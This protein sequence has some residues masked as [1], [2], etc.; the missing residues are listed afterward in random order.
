MNERT[1][2]ALGLLLGVGSGKPPEEWLQ[3]AHGY[4]R[5]KQAED[6]LNAVVFTVLVGAAAFYAAERGENPKVNSYFDA[7]VYVSTNL[8]VGYS[9]IFARTEAG[10]AIG[11]T[12]MTYGPALAARAFDQPNEAKERAVDG[13]RSEATLR[14]IA[15]KLELI[16]QELQ[17]QRGA[18]APHG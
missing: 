12:L 8:S 7:L 3:S 18:Q 1:L 2:L 10:K 11:T 4:F 16:L 15:N 9:D 5:D 6:P 13:E 17:S 14:D